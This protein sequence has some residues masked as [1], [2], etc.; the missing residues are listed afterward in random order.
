MYK[1]VCVYVNLSFSKRETFVLEIGF[2]DIYLKFIIQYFH[3]F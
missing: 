3:T 2:K 1:D